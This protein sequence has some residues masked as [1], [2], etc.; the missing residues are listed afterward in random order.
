MNKRYA[1]WRAREAER[2]AAEE[3]EKAAHAKRWA[4]VREYAVIIL[5]I[6]EVIIGALMYWRPHA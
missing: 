4:L 1:Q 6:V 2:R 5:F 3:A